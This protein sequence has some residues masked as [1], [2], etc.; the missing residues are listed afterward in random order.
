MLCIEDVERNQA[1]AIA[2]SVLGA[3]APSWTPSHHPVLMRQQMSTRRARGATA[4]SATPPWTPCGGLLCRRI[5]RD[6]GALVT[7]L[8]D[9]ARYPRALPGALAIPESVYWIVDHR[10]APGACAPS[11]KLIRAGE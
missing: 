6:H 11:G 7:G 4:A 9:A 2:G 10:A 1:M 5:A 3:H 8:G